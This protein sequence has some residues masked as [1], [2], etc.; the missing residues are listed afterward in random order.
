MAHQLSAPPAPLQAKVKQLSVSDDGMGVRQPAPV[1]PASEARGVR[2]API[3]DLS[4]EPDDHR[5]AHA[6]TVIPKSVETKAVIMKALKGHYLFSSLDDSEILDI[7]NAMSNVQHHAGADIILQGTPGNVFYILESGACAILV[8]NEVVG[9]YASGDAFGELALLYNSPRAAT[10]KALAPCSLWTV[11]RTSFRKILATT[12]STMQL[13]RVQFLQNV[14]LLQRLSNNQLQKVAAA[15]K[16]ETFADGSYIIR[17]G[18][19]G[20]LFYI[21]VEGTVLCT[22]TTINDGEKPLMS[23]T[24][25][26][27]FGEM[28]LMLNEPRQANCIAKGK[29]AC[30]VLG[31]NEFTQLL[32]PLRS[33]LDRQMRIRVLRSV[34]LLN[35]LTDDELDLLAHALRVVSYE[36]K[37]QILRQGDAGD[38]F[39]IISDGKVSVQKTGIEI[40]QL[41]SGEFF[42][43][44]ALLSKEP[45]AAN[46]FANGHVECL[47]L[48]RSAF[49]RLLGKLEHILTRETKRQQLMQEA[50]LQATTPSHQQVVQPKKYA[51]ADFEKIQTIGTGTFGRVL[52]VKHKTTGK[53]FA[54]KCM[55]KV[56]IVETHQQR[57]VLHE[58]S[59]INECE[60]PFVLKLYETFTDADQLYMLLELVQGGELWSLLYEKAYNVPKG[61]CGAFDLPSARFYIANVVE[62]F[63][64]LQTLGVAYRDLKPENLMIDDKGYLKMVDFG[65]AKHIPFYKGSQLCER[66]FTLCGTPEYLAPEL[67]LNKGHGKSVDYWALGCLIYELIAGRTPFQHQEQQ[68]I[69]EKIIHAKASLKFHPKFDPLAQDL[70][71]KLLEPN[72][73]LRLGSLAGGMMEVVNHPWFANAKFD[74]KALVAKSMKA[75]YVPTIKS[76]VDVSN[77]DRCSEGASIPKYTG[78][79][80]FENF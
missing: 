62:V 18:E 44:R 42:G 6:A 80:F 19:E 10:I 53:T 1:S 12:A 15:M 36:D 30:Y 13:S 22:T 69:F 14:D 67:V 55:L 64:Y 77:F 75:P 68:K 25:G 27:Y 79:E 56:N 47:C 74:W 59:I 40:M 51:L 33:L 21:V 5:V 16:L 35:Y 72:P 8:N 43:E 20:H 23:L 45:R 3:N 73:G 50:V 71:T 78:E 60:H 24:K 41:R 2:R 32:G 70:V 54:L 65:F 76:G 26:Q 37:E 57:N 61:V 39:Y 52:M 7:M 66:S 31:R 34:P 58:K 49:E 29:V 4:V 63:R 28:A 38:T 48:D 11:D 9:Q 17:Q 46:C